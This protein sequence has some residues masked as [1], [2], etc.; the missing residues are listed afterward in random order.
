MNGIRRKVEKACTH[1]PSLLSK[2][3]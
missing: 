3:V 1:P 2:R